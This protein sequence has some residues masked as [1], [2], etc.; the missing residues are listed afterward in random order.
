MNNSYRFIVNIAI[1]VSIIIIVAGVIELVSG[2]SLW[3][4]VSETLSSPIEALNRQDIA[5]QPTPAPVEAAPDAGCC[6][7]GS[8][9]SDEQ[10]NPTAVMS[11]STDESTSYVMDTALPQYATMYWQD[12]FTNAS[13][14]WEPYFEISG[15]LPVYQYVNTSKPQTA[16]LTMSDVSYVTSSATAWNG[17][18]GGDYSFTLPGAPMTKDNA[19]VTSITPYLWDFNIAQPLPTYPYLV[20]VSVSTTLSSGAMVVL[21]FAGDVNNVS[22]GSGILVM[23]PMRQNMGVSFI[24]DLNNQFVVWEFNNNR[25]WRLGCTQSQQTDYAAVYS[26]QLQGQFVVDQTTLAIAVKGN[27]TP[28]VKVQCARAFNGNS[29]TARFL[30]IGSRFWSMQVPVPYAN[31]LRFHNVTVA[32]P[33]SAQLNDGSYLFDGTVSEIGDMSC[34]PFGSGSVDVTLDDALRGGCFD[35]ISWV[36]EPFPSSKRVAWPAQID[37]SGSWQCGSAEPFAN[38]DIRYEQDYAVMQIAG[39]EYRVVATEKSDYP[40]MVVHNPVGY[41]YDSSAVNKWH[42]EAQIGERLASLSTTWFGVRMNPDATLQTSWMDASCVR[43]N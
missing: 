32:Q 20:D 11:P 31:V 26:T 4:R 19:F 6:E 41:N 2:R 35:T 22:A 17:Y 7:Q 29:T 39:L 3:N 9:V 10:T 24:G 14:G 13:S 5:D 8:F 37:I 40:F 38:F 33:D 28:D 34:D 18:D 1:G 15:E 12:D 43:V 27:N 36:T 21:D 16:D 42:A 25:L 30:G 23:M